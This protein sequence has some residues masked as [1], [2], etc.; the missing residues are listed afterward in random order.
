MCSSTPVLQEGVAVGVGRVL[1]GSGPAFVD[2]HFHLFRGAV[3]ADLHHHGLPWGQAVV[4]GQRRGTVHQLHRHLERS[5]TRDHV[6]DHV[7]PGDKWEK[8]SW[9]DFTSYCKQCSYL[10][11]FNTLRDDL[12]LLF[13]QKK[14]KISLHIFK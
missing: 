6:F 2:D 13:C 10:Q 12:M 14:N 7:I 1:G 5:Q 11:K 3:Q 4:V 9:N 8:R